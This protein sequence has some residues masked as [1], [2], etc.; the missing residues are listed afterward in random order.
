M[1]PARP[2]PRGV[3]IEQHPLRRTGV[4]IRHH[5][6]RHL[7][8]GLLTQVE[9]PLARGSDTVAPHALAGTQLPQPGAQLVAAG[10]RAEEVA[11]IL[12]LPVQPGV[13]LAR[14]LLHPPVRVVD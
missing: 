2:V 5:Q 9:D 12:R 11:G 6:H 3:R 8:A 13:E 7:D 4:R 10:Q 1:R 14:L